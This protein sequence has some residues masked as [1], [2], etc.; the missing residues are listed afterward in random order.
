VIFCVQ[1]VKVRGDCFVDIGGTVD[2]YCLSL[3]TWSDS[4]MLHA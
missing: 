3:F 2:H 1:S 4:L